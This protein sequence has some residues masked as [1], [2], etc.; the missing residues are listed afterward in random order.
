MKYISALLLAV[1]SFAS[2]AG[3]QVT[4]ATITKLSL[5]NSTAPGTL[6]IKT[7]GGTEVTQKNSCVRTS[8]SYTHQL[9]NDELSRS[10]YSMLLTAKTAKTKVSIIGSGSCGTGSYA[11]TLSTISLED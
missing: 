4:G 10:I 5:S 3:Y 11:E 9:S 1:T 7:E 8:W 2:Q 6:F